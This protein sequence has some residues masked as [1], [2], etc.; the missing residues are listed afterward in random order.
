MRLGETELDQ[1]GKLRTTYSYPVQVLQFGDDLTLV[2]LAGE[3]VVDYAL[4]LKAELPGPAIWVAGFSNDSATCLP[5]G[6]CGKGA[7]MAATPCATLRSPAPLRRQWRSGLWT[8]CTGWSTKCEHP[9]ATSRRGMVPVRQKFV[10]T[11]YG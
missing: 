8:W 4:R 10:I 7:T 1:T 3:V 2:A 6:Y 5:C 9:G 11:C